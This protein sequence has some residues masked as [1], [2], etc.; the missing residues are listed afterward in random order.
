MTDVKKVVL[1]SASPKIGEDSASDLLV[2]LQDKQMNLNNLMVTRLNVRQCLT[3][4]ETETAFAA[5]SEADG[6]V[7][8]FPLYFF[9]LPGMLMRFLQ[10]YYEFVL[11]HRE[12]VR[13]AKVYAVVNC[14]FPEADINQEAIRVIKNFSDQIG[15]QFRM[16]ISIGGG[17]MLLGAK[18]APIMKK[19]IAELNQAFLTIANDILGYA[20]AIPD[21]IYIQMRFPRRLYLMSGNLG[22][23]SKAH[24]HGLKKKDLYRA[25][26]C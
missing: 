3:R 17:G 11:K 20:S 24:K 22:W 5:M 12:A 26:Y 23:I 10:D 9:C 15:A 13:K 14:G 4:R 7:I 18:D 2:D 8:T 19:T 1:L 6:L 21:N 25:P 16:G